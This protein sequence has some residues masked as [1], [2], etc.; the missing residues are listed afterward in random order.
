MSPAPE[1]RPL[2]SSDTTAAVAL[3]AFLNPECPPDVLRERYETMLRQYPHY[4]NIG[5]FVDNRLVGLAGVWVATKI[6]C[7][8]HLEIDN[9]VVHP[10]HRNS[11]VGSALFRLIEDFAKEQECRCMTLD[12]YAT[13]RS[14]HRLYHRMGFEIW[15]FHFVKPIGNIHT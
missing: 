7:G 9:L 2:T 14:S 8:R 1:I 11:G 3:L 12:S 13:N 5:A 4:H 6:W 15:S 10:A